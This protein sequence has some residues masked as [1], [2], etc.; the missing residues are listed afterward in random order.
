MDG[1]EGHERGQGV[2]DDAVS[3]CCET[4]AKLHL[5]MSKGNGV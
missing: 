2:D 4:G 1:R 3:V 5:W